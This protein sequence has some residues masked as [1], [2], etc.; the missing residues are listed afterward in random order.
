[1]PISRDLLEAALVGY[2]AQIA[3]IQQ[4]MADIRGKLNGS[5][6]TVIATLPTRGKR[7]LSAASRKKM[8]A[9]QKA[10]WEAFRAQ[11]SGKA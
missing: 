3:T 9:A 4:A 10:R 8:A 5:G 6:S 11:K 2:Q 1:M 7:K